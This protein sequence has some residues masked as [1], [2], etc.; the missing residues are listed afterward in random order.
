MKH[1]KTKYQIKN[2][3]LFGKEE[4]EKNKVRIK[5]ELLTENIARIYEDAANSI[6]DFKPEE[7]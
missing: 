1:Y 6:D 7:E 5:S 4:Y 2:S 3:E